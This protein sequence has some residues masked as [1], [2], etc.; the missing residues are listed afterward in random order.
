MVVDVFSLDLGDISSCRINDLFWIPEELKLF[1]PQAIEI[2][3]VGLRPLDKDHSWHC[4]STDFVRERINGHELDGRVVLALSS[5]LWLSP[6]H[7]RKKVNGTN[8]MVVVTD[9][10]KELLDTHRAEKNE[11][12]LQ[13]LYN[14]CKIGQISLSD[15]SIGIAPKRL[16]DEPEVRYAFLP[17][18]QDVKVK[19]ARF[20][21][22][23]KFYVTTVD[24]QRLVYELES[25]ISKEVR[26]TFF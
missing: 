11:E 7:E 21:N 25:D 12:H 24:Y 4:R 3:L 1:P 16:V 2:F 26:N 19:V 14:T 6:L 17:L 18:S 20:L 9:I 22:P 15:Y 8:A 10:F 5:T 13:K 23:E